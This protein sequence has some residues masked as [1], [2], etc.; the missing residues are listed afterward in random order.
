MYCAAKEKAEAENAKQARRQNKN[1]PVSRQVLLKQSDK[2]NDNG[3][4]KG[5]A[6]QE[7]EDLVTCHLESGFDDGLEDICGVISLLPPE[8]AS[9]PVKVWEEKDI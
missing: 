7:D 3:K 9:N 4:D 5:K 1:P 2:D 8:F 6:P